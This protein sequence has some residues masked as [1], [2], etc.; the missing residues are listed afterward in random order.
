MNFQMKDFAQGLRNINREKKSEKRERKTRLTE[1]THQKNT[2]L[3]QR[4]YDP[5]C[6]NKWQ[7]SNCEI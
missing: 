1:N 2:A 5:K 7:C 6:W 3:E 4:H